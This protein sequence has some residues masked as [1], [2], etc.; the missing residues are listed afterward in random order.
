MTEPAKVKNKQES[1]GSQYTKK[2]KKAFV[3]HKDSFEI[4]KNY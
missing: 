2:V 4:Y 1:N 3:G